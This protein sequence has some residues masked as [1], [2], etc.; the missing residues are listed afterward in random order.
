MERARSGPRGRQSRRKRIPRSRNGFC[1]E[2]EIRGSKRQGA[3]STKEHLR[4]RGFCSSRQR[5]KRN[6]G[7]TS[8]G[9]DCSEMPPG[10]RGGKVSNQ[11][12]RL[13][14]I[15]K[16]N[17]KKQYMSG[18]GRRIESKD[19]QPTGRKKGLPASR[20]FF[21]WK[22]R[23]GAAKSSEGGSFRHTGKKKI[24][25]EKKPFLGRTTNKGERRELS[26]GRNFGKNRPDFGGERSSPGWGE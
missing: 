4:G 16:R 5:T 8:Q 19:N 21:L 15:L 6:Q 14:K 22:G 10:G 7:A 17:F 13:E 2:R 23:G 3:I 20:K 1:K 24:A 9:L 26:R 25:E 12:N 11:A 18:E